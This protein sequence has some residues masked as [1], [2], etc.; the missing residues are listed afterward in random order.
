[1]MFSVNTTTLVA[2][3]CFKRNKGVCLAQDIFVKYA[4]AGAVDA[5]KLNN[6]W[7][8]PYVFSFDDNMNVNDSSGL[9]PGYA[10]RF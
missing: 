3:K 10:D 5:L 4:P 9:P 8:K 1:M 2:M 6:F 7:E